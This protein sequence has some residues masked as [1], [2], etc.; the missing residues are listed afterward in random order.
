MKAESI[1]N[2]IKSQLRERPLYQF[3]SE[4]AQVFDLAAGPFGAYSKS[5]L[6][7]PFLSSNW[8]KLE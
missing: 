3:F 6:K 5:L 8:K 1:E 7:K 4:L 2:K